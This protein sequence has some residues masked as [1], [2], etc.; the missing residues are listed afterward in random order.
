VALVAIVVFPDLEDPEM[1]Y[2]LLMLRYLPVGALGLVVASFVAAFMSTVSTQINWGASYLVNDLYARFVNPDASQKR[3]VA[4]GRLASVIIVAFAAVAA[5]F[6]NDIGT[7]FRFMIAIGTGPGA[8]LILRWFWWRVNASAELASMIAG[9]G[10]ALATYL[11][12]WGGMGFGLRL[13][14]TAFGTAAV[15]IPVMYLTRP[16]SD[17]TLDAFY[18]RVRPGGSGWNEVRART[19]LEPITLLR[20]DA[21]RTV[22][23]TAVLFGGMF[24]VGGAML[25]EPGLAI[26][27]AL[28]LVAGLAG[29]RALGKR[30]VA[31]E[32]V[33]P[34]F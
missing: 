28:L 33:D 16:E 1:G 2:P 12:V 26:G 21:A 11:P 34:D 13:A 8:V 9:F 27:S 30:H 31:A 6:A 14:I 19:G 10:I 20:Y 32:A 24:A 18:R 17:A 3:L 22:A 5:F 15:W 4:L 25:A 29:L 7:V 23:A